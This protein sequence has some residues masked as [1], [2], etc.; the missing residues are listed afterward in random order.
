MYTFQRECLTSTSREERT[1]ISLEGCEQ[2]QRKEI[3]EISG[4]RRKER[5][6]K[7]KRGEEEELSGFGSERMPLRKRKFFKRREPHLFVIPARLLAA[8]YRLRLPKNRENRVWC[9]VSVLTLSSVLSHTTQPYSFSRIS[10]E[11]LTP[12]SSLLG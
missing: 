12:F 11:T 3:G 8:L 2:E 7:F 4:K 10:W 9:G 6:A 5:W 1:P